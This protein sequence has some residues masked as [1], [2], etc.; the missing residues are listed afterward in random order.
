MFGFYIKSHFTMQ[1]P[2]MLYI[3]NFGGKR[4]FTAEK[5]LSRRSCFIYLFICGFTTTF[6]VT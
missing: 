4:L 6:L 1:P 2:N 5:W 3:N